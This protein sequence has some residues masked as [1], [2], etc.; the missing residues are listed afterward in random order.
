LFTFIPLFLINMFK[1][2]INLYFLLIM[3]ATGAVDRTSKSFV[4]SVLAL[5]FLLVFELI[6]EVTEEALRAVSDRKI[7]EQQYV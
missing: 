4:A 6:K 5:L 3:I 7:N 2:L 1:D